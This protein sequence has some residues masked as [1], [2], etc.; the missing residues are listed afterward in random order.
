MES[1][2]LP[3]D[4]SW[5]CALIRHAHRG[6]TTFHPAHPVKRSR[7]PPTCTT[8]KHGH[9]GY[10]IFKP[11]KRVLTS[12]SKRRPF[13]VVL[14]GFGPTARWCIGKDWYSGRKIKPRRRAV[15]KLVTDSVGYVIPCIE[16][17]N[18]DRAASD[19]T[20]IHPTFPHLIPANVPQ[21][22]TP[23]NPTLYPLIE[24]SSSL[25]EQLPAYR[26]AE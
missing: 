12:R 5:T 6:A 2:S 1:R 22:R 17:R 15:H 8:A 20:Q 18:R 4:A 14:L 24:V 7:I 13:V 21:H 16:H 26:A 19:S 3:L 11:R 10:T 25:T 9:P 23:H